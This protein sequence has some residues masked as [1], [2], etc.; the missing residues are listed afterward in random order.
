LL[1]IHAARFALPPGARADHEI[2]CAGHDGI[3]ELIHE[4]RA[5]A[6]IA[7]EKNDDVAFR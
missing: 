2:V 7:V 5:I 1:K 3:D 6:A 4:L